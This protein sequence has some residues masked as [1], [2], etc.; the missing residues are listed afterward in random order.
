MTIL[1]N[2]TVPVTLNPGNPVVTLA[3]VIDAYGP[4]L[5]VVTKSSG[6]V[7]DTFN[8][9]G[10]VGGRG[11]AFNVT[12]TGIVETGGSS[13]FAAAIILASPGTIKNTG[14]IAGGSGILMFG[15]TGYVRNTGLIN[16]RGVVGVYLYKGGGITNTGEISGGQ[17][18][19]YLGD[20]GGI[21]NSGTVAGD[22][23]IVAIYGAANIYN[24]GRVIGSSSSG[25]AFQGT[26]VNASSGIIQ[27]EAS[28]V[29]ITTGGI[30]NHGRIG[31]GNGIGI[32]IQIGDSLL[33]RNTGE[34]QGRYAIQS[35]AGASGT[36][37][38]Y[39]ASPGSIAGGLTAIQLRGAAGNYDSIGNAGY[40]GAV[41]A[42][43]S[44]QT[45]RIVNTGTIR[46]DGAG[47]ITAAGPA[48][49]TSDGLIQGLRYG[50]ALS[51][52]GEI[53][54]AGRVVGDVSFYRNSVVDN[55][56]LIS[57]GILAGSGAAV[58][59][60][61]TGSIDAYGY[62]AYGIRDYGGVIVNDGA[63][64]A[65]SSQ[66]I[67]IEGGGPAAIIFN[68]GTI[69]AT[70]ASDTPDVYGI[71]LLGAATIISTGL[72]EGSGAAIVARA[73][74]TI[75]NAGRIDGLG[76]SAIDL[77]A[78]PANRLILDPG[79]VISGGVTLNGALELAAGKSAA[80]V[81]LA[82]FTD[83]RGITIDHGATW[84]ILGTAG[85]GA[86][87]YNYGTLRAAGT[88]T[89]LSAIGPVYNYG[90]IKAGSG[91][92]DAGGYVYNSGIVKALGASGIG[93]A[94]TAPGY[95]INTAGASVSGASGVS[96]RAHSQ[97]YNY[98]AITGGVTAGASG[99][100][101]NYAG[102]HIAGGVTLAGGAIYNAGTIDSVDFTGSLTNRLTLARNAGTGTIE[103]FAAGDTIDLAGIALAKITGENFA[104]GILTLTETAGSF[105]LTFANPSSLATETFALFADGRGTGITLT[106]AAAAPALTMPI[107]YVPAAN[108]AQSAIVKNLAA[109]WITHETPAM[110][111]AVFHPI[112]I[113]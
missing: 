94:L 38:I 63:I 68:G 20:T 91:I 76:G 67:R 104:A 69:S 32:G 105:T 79:A 27:C 48:T 59:V 54:N 42:A 25:I 49:I 36:T 71:Y 111:E 17:A 57:G 60:S 96:L 55:A 109:G 39:N 108:Q 74:A 35:N 77:F 65:T 26:L 95:V 8:L 12:N 43:V 19:I 64:A 24:S 2:S 81:N 80:K 16:A 28:A 22:T 53:I 61:N 82:P 18:G 47:A 88:A 10:A 44:I 34:V 101:Y 46:S 51:G 97:L 83:I 52:G 21:T 78:G 75:I 6:G 110:P 103:N 40:I 29:S 1:G 33:L 4:L 87:V 70:N 45:G 85:A 66:A 30:D 73:G 112:T 23:G 37:E 93:I 107:A 14:T 84:Q 86:A 58:D 92:A 99:V 41:G 13:T 9:Y 15:A 56:G 102:G 5:G 50:L 11:A 106:G 113:S 31:E 89:A 62:R 100:I 7:L 90:L 3:G 72:I 98:G